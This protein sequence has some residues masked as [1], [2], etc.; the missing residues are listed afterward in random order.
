MIHQRQLIFKPFE[1]ERKMVQILVVGGKK[2]SRLAGAGRTGGR[3]RPR[4]ESAGKGSEGRD[5]RFEGSEI[6]GR[7]AGSGRRLCPAWSEGSAAAGRAGRV[8]T[9]GSNQKER[10]CSDFLNTLYFYP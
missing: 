1:K 9:E 4:G 5:R 3:L 6:R 7:C 2:F 10:G 8:A